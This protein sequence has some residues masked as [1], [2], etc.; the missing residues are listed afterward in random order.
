MGEEK[1]KGG[2]DTQKKDRALLVGLYTGGVERD[3]CHEHLEELALLADTYGVEVVEAVPCSVRK[4]D[5]AILVGAGKLEELIATAHEE[6][7]DL[8]IFDE[9]ISPAQQRNLEK[10]FGR[11]VFDLSLIHI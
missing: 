8:I 10:A 1:G 11:T 9:E 3:A 6:G 4:R 7:V 2:I 5:A